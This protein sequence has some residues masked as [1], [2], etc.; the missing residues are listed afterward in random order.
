MRRSYSFNRGRDAYG[1]MDEG[2]LF[3]CFQSD[4]GR[5][6]EAVQNRLAGEAL[7]HYTLTVG[8]GYFFAPAPD[9]LL[10]WPVA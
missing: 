6:F 3:T 8:G 4:L 2:L 10:R 7:S 5:G 9:A 1:Q